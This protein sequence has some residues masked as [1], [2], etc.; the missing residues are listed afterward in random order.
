V[1]RG[2]KAQRTSAQKGFNGPENVSRAQKFR[3]KER[4]DASGVTGLIGELTLS[5]I[6]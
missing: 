4:N 2:R 1:V 3:F 6:A 5:L